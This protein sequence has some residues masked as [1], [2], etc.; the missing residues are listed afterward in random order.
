[1]RKLLASCLAALCLTLAGCGGGHQ[2]EQNIKLPDQMD[3]QQEVQSSGSDFL[4]QAEKTEAPAVSG[5]QA[6]SGQ[7]TGI[8]RAPDAPQYTVDISSGNGTG[9]TIEITCSVSSQENTVWQ[10][11]GLYDDIWEGI[12]YIGTKYKD[13]TSEGVTVERVSVPERE[14]I[15]G[16]LYLEEYGVLHWLDEF[17]HTGDNLYFVKD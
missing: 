11:T 15:T 16:L 13:I 10:L 4:P 17:D 5:D 8:W 1:M 6:F 3:T 7:F 9:Y 12:A 14:E 2:E